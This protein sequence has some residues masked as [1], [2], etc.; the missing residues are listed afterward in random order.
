MEHSIKTNNFSVIFEI[1]DHCASIKKG[2]FGD[3]T[4]LPSPIFSATIERLSDKEEFCIQ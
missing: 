1:T 2:I 4:L 3:I